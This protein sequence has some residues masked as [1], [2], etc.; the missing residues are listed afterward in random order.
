MIKF[1]LLIVA[2]LFILTATFQNC[3]EPQISVVPP[4]PMSSTLAGKFCSQPPSNE[5][6]NVN[7]IFLI[8]MS[9]SNIYEASVI[10]KG[11]DVPGE[12]FDAVDA[13]FSEECLKKYTNKRFAI[14]GFSSEILVPLN[15]TCTADAL[16]KDINIAK[17]QVQSLRDI[18]QNIINRNYAYTSNLNPMKNTYYKKALDC[19]NN[20]LDSQLSALTDDE[21][22]TQSYLTFFIT[23]GEPTDNNSLGL[24]IT[25]SNVENAVVAFNNYFNS[26]LAKY[27]ELTN[28]QA[29]GG[30]LQ[31]VIYGFNRINE[32][33][34]KLAQGVLNNIAEKGDSLLV[35]T[36][37]VN[38]L[39]LCDILTAGLKQPYIVRKFGVVN[40]TAKMIKGQLYA[41]S[42]M[43]GIIDLDEENL[44]FDPT[45]RR[46]RVNGNQLLDGLCFGLKA[47]KCPA[48]LACGPSNALGFNSCDIASYSMTDGVDTDKDDIPDIIEVLKGTLPNHNDA[49]SNND[50]DTLPLHEEIAIGRDPFFKDDGLDR[51][52]LLQYSHYKSP[53]SLIEC[54]ANQQAWTFQ[55]DHVPTIPTLATNNTFDEDVKIQ[56]LNHEKD[57]NIILVY[58]II[59][60]VNEDSDQGGLLFGHF[61]KV[62]YPEILQDEDREFELLGE[63]DGDF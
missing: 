51:S 36:D 15:S 40:L 33:G 1:I 13:F 17:G 16:T 58:Y 56:F 57:E 4:Q 30:R 59:K 9:G 2:P 38:E 21:K 22:K 32:V 63:I 28:K 8:D 62:K 27:L 14:I 20:V 6:G 10:N 43:D 61:V 18:Q 12:R 46:S 25:E 19:M 48:Q 5:S 34:K 53:E 50:G 42:D 29:G 26:S 39:K 11:T 55:I 49:F 60:K 45:R 52:F 7:F 24:S 47:K 31:P 37:R 35:S 3:S 41:D 54:P 23:D 44:G